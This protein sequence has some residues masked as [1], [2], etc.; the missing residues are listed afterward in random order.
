MLAWPGYVDSGIDSAH[1]ASRLGYCGL[2]YNRYCIAAAGRSTTNP[3]PICALG[4]VYA[5]DCNLVDQVAHAHAALCLSVFIER[6]AD[7]CD[8]YLYREICVGL[9]LNHVVCGVS[10]IVTSGIIGTFVKIGSPREDED[11]CPFRRFLGDCRDHRRYV[12][13]SCYWT[14]PKHSISRH[15]VLLHWKSYCYLPD[16]DINK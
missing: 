1:L 3:F 11:V 4:L 16:H 5:E 8:L 2:I 10:V 6:Y 7:D 9:L 15:L 14:L 13:F 12:L